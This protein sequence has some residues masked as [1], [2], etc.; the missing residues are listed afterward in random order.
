[1]VLSNARGS[2][3]SIGLIALDIDGTL[4]GPDRQFPRAVA[5]KLLT[6]HQSDWKIVFAT[7]RS[8]TFGY[9]VLRALPF[10]Y[11]YI[12]YN[13]ALNLNMPERQTQ[14]QHVLPCGVLVQ[15][16][17]ACRELG[18]PLFVHHYVAERD[19]CYFVKEGMTEDMR[20]YSDRRQQATEEQWVALNSLLTLPLTH[21]CYAKCFGSLDQMRRLQKTIA[22]LGEFALIVITDPLQPNQ[23]ILL[24]SHPLA[25]KGAAVH[26]MRQVIP[27]GAPVIAAGDDFNDLSMLQEADVAIVMETAPQELK[28]WADIVAPP[29]AE[30]GIVLGLEQALERICL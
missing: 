22:T 9:S 23:A 28:K 3:S 18:V 16:E 13:G 6:L 20:L 25:N 7:G 10:S 30:C 4:V 5:E 11:S 24:V 15:I 8:F 12:C 14:R 17:R 21:F 27:S 2:H 26:E 29:A 19:Q 1:M